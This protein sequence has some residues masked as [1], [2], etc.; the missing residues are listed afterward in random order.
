MVRINLLPWRE[1]ERTRRLYEFFFMLGAGAIVAAIVAVQVHL[2]METLIENKM[3][4]L[5]LVKKEQQ[6]LANKIKEVKELDKKRDDLRSR[7]DIIQKRQE[8]RP[9]VV[10]LFDELVNITP[11]GLYLTSLTQKGNSLIITGRAQSNARISALMRNIENS[12][13]LEKPILS[14]IQ[15]G[16]RSKGSDFSEFSIQAQQLDKPKPPPDAPTKQS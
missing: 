9:V 14:I 3:M 4:Q 16:N 5:E 12:A 11:E 2:Y 6:E 10:H 13:W 1:E 15:G 8:S 7:M